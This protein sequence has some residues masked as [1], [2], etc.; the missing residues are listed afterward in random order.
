MTD[1]ASTARRKKIRDSE[2]Q[3]V[4][5]YL[6][7]HPAFFKDHPSVLL[8]LE[9]PHHTGPATSLV[10]Y[11]SRQLRDR[12]AR[13]ERKLD[14]LVNIA[15]ENEALMERVHRMTLKVMDT[16]GLESL[17]DQVDGLLRED[18]GAD[19]VRILI[20][21]DTLPA[22]END[23]VQFLP[24][25]DPGLKPFAAFRREA[26]PLCGRLRPDQLDVLFGDD[27]ERIRSAAVMP[28]DDAVH[29][30]ALGLGSFEPDRFHPG[31]G[32]VFLKLM[33][34]ILGRSLN[35]YAGGQAR[36]RA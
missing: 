2:T 27:A 4:I 6:T 11:Q 35:Q 14:E 10:E 1:K 8:R 32:T 17:V 30:G 16:E 23:S 21:D 20:F 18:F 31:M 15:R 7:R 22:L 28:L 19:R 36:R 34:Q 26:K 24:P 33:G 3:S 25:D 12:N 9:I 29:I 13:L 5:D